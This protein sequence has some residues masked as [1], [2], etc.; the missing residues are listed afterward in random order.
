[1]NEAGKYVK[2]KWVTDIRHDAP[3]CGDTDCNQDRERKMVAISHG[4][5]C[6]PCI[7]SLVSA[8]YN[9]GIRTVA[10]CCGHG[11]RPGVIMLADGR[12]LLIARNAEMARRM[13]A[14]FPAINDPLPR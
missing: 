13:D 8:L 10:S 12:E 4:V 1:M 6:D 14:G 9:V 11:R 5:W 2:G 7:V 3:P